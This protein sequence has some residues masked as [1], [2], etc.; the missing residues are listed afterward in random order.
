MKENLHPVKLANRKE[1]TFQK[2]ASHVNPLM[3][4]GNKKVT[5]T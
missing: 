4:V 1:T 5:H 3:P 2:V